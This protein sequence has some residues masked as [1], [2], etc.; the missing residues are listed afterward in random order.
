M[1]VFYRELAA[2]W[3]LISPVEEYAAEARELLRLLRERRAG[4][5]T[6]LELGSGGGHLA[7]HLAPEFECHLTDLSPAMLGLSRE[8]NPACAHSIGDMRTLD[9]QRTFDIVLVYDGID[10]MTTEHDL[11]AVFDTAWR[12]LS[13]GGLACFIPDDVAESFEPGTDVSG[14]DAPDGSGARLF[15]WSEPVAPGETVATVHYSFL[16]RDRDG[17]VQTFY[18]RHVCGLFPQATWERLLTER[19]FHVEVVVEE[20]DDDRA[21]RLVFLAHKPG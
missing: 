16:I 10:Y 8:L 1:D 3:S 13:A 14:G 6:L 4:A 19:G 11:G 20:T 7:H 21:G 5:R 2:Y 17:Q 18:E 9:L 15:E 12:H